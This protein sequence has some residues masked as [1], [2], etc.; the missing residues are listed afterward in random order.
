[1]RLE[2]ATMRLAKY[3]K[4]KEDREDLQDERRAERLGGA[5]SDGVKEILMGL[6]S[7]TSSRSRRTRMCGSPQHALQQQQ[8]LA[9]N[10]YMNQHMLYGYGFPAMAPPALDVCLWSGGDRMSEKT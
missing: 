2:L 7:I 1:M 10:P 9:M 3:E 5:F 8:N 6:S 4:E